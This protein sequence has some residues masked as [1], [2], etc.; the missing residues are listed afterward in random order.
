M[1]HFPQGC[2]DSR[3]SNAVV[4]AIHFPVGVVMGVDSLE[5]QDVSITGRL[6]TM[7]RGQAVK[8][9][10]AAGGSYSKFPKRNTNLLLVGQSGWPL[11]RDGRLTR[12][13]RKAKQMQQEGMAIQILQETDFLRIVGLDEEL[14]HLSRLYS[15]EQ[16]S[17]VI[18][19]PVA[20][21]RSWT[22]VGLIQPATVDKRLAWFDFREIVSAQALQK[23]LDSGLT[24]GQLKRSLEELSQWLPAGERILNRLEAHSTSKSVR[25]RLPKGKLAESTGQLLLDFEASESASVA[26]LEPSATDKIVLTADQWFEIG[27]DAEDR[28]DFEDAIAA[29]E[30]ALSGDEAKAD[31]CFNL[32]NVL[33]YL[34]RRT[35]AVKRYEEAVEIDEQFVEAWNNLGNVLSELGRDGEAIRAYETALRHVPSHADAHYNLAETLERLGRKEEAHQHRMAYLSVSPPRTWMSQTDDSE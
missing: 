5:G 22:R 26:S 9:I 7:T 23:L 35:D 11:Q 10:Q 3:D 29:Y 34:G 13:I 33:H 4:Y 20:Q 28:G 25:V 16:L 6:V 32:G 17:R 18:N 8:H 24:M 14:E 30:Q 1:I 15:G 2:V 19:V 21:I 31:V 27:A 12:K